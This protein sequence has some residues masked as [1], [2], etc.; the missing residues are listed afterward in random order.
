MAIDWYKNRSMES[1]VQSKERI[2]YRLKE[3]R[4]QVESI[5]EQVGYYERDLRS[6]EI[7]I[8]RRQATINS[9]EAH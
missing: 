7:E 3:W 9:T 5:E 8:R 2:E 6:L 4:S 1:L